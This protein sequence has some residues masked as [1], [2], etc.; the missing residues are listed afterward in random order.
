[1]NGYLIEML[2]CS[3]EAPQVCDQREE[4]MQAGVALGDAEKSAEWVALGEEEK[5]AEDHIDQ[6]KILARQS[7]SVADQSVAAPVGV[8][9]G[10]VGGTQAKYHQKGH[11]QEPI[12]VD[13]SVRAL[14]GSGPVHTFSYGLV[15]AL[16]G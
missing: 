13:V 12:D 2:E 9:L 8:L 10:R 6:A 7:A 5:P 1:M 14:D 11:R 16:Q 4:V 15:M 3:L